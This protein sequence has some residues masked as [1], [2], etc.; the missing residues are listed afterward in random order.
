MFPDLER[1][2]LHFE[3]EEL[4]MST[5]CNSDES[6]F[7]KLCSTLQP[8]LASTSLYFPLFRTLQFHVLFSHLSG[9]KN[10]FFF[11]PDRFHL[12]RK[13][14]RLE[15][16]FMFYSLCSI[17]HE[18]LATE[19]FCQESFCNCILSSYHNL[20]GYCQYRKL[21]RLHVW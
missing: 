15:V 8:Q 5:V 6:V 10:H 20:D 16:G 12:F 13:Q 7:E 9:I 14:I 1:S 17:H 21:K 11:S 4:G 18:L 19:N 2:Q 3:D